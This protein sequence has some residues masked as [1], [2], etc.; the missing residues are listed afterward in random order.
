MYG[1]ALW[2]KAFQ[3]CAESKET[4]S[5]SGELKEMFKYLRL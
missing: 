3:Y 4:A 1:F 5:F 2:I